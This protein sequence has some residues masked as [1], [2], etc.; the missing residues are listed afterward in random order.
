MP[1][2]N[3]NMNQL[4]KFRT[5]ECQVQFRITVQILKCEGLVTWMLRSSGL[6]VQMISPSC[7]S[8]DGLVH[9]SLGLSVRMSWTFLL[10][11]F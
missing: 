8:F 1:K 5:S 11:D 9:I 6:S 3:S 2:T 7:Q 4:N 10:D